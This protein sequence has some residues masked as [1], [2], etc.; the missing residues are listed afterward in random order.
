VKLVKLVERFKPRVVLEI[1]TA[2]GG[3][4]FL[5]T[6]ASDPRGTIISI[7]LP[8]GPFG[9]GYPNWMVPLFKSFAKKKQRIYLIKANSHNINTLNAVEEILGGNAIDFLFIDGDHSYEGI[10]MDF[11]MYYPLIKSGG[12]IAIHD[13]V[14]HNKIHDPQGIIGI[15]R[16]WNEVKDSYKN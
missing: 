14:P 15:D 5:L 4:L 2:C 16:F 11:E 13:I 6:R 1:G 10:K 3:S 7:D 12:I 9:G 8:G